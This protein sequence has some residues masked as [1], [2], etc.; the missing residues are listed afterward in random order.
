M[1]RIKPYCTGTDR[2]NRNRLQFQLLPGEC[3][4]TIVDCEEFMLTAMPGA[5][6]ETNPIALRW[7]AN[8]FTAADGAGIVGG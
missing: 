2:P 8:H 1:Q 3:P 6:L 4:S 5:T 7:P